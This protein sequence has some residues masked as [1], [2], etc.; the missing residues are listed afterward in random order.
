VNAVRTEKPYRKNGQR[1]QR[2]FIN[3]AELRKEVK[4]GGRTFTNIADYLVKYHGYRNFD[5]VVGGQREGS[6][7][8]FTIR[9][10]G[11]RERWLHP[12][13]DG[14]VWAEQKGG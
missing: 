6:E 8:A 9:L 1:F 11:W 10:K 12:T 5:L 3:G 14:T 2:V 4:E 13:P 7:W